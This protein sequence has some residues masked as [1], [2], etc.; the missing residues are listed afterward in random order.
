METDITIVGGGLSGVCA[1]IAAARLGQSVALVQNRPVLGG[2]SSSEIR[3]WVVG[4]TSH[5]INRFARET[6]IMGEL[7]VENQYRN[8][9]GNPY[10]WDLTVLEAVKAEKNIQLFLNTDVHEIEMA[11]DEADQIQSVTGWIMGSE[12]RIQFISSMFL[13]CTGDGLIGFLAGANFRIGREAR[14]EFGE[15]WAPETADAITLGSTI[16]FYT[17][18]V[19][20][21]VK[22]IPPKLAKDITTTSIPIK[23]V[24]R[25]GD[26]GCH[27]WWIEWGGELDTL[28][29]NELIRDELTSVIYGVWDYIKNSGK[30]EADSLTL[31]WVGSIPGKP[32]K[33][34]VETVNAIH[35]RFNCTL[36]WLLIRKANNVETNIK[37][38]ASLSLIFDSYLGK[39]SLKK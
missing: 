31:E 11:E 7:F 10:L 19:G 22:Y 9:E 14:S 2:N 13:D 15:D 35:E 12:R 28:H 39:Q 37:E 23:R 8:P 24:I 38:A 30:F 17:K 29:D 1:A 26:S 20:Q 34:S 18:D 21:T 33:P 3:V 25:S 32:S 6:G 16:L 4:A 36:V 27:Y 5:G